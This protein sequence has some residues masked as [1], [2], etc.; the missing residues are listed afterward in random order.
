MAA[1]LTE[2]KR[3]RTSKKKC[4]NK[5]LI[6]TFFFLGGE[7]FIQGRPEKVVSRTTPLFAVYPL[8]VAIIVDLVMCHMGKNER[9]QTSSI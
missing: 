6:L 5:E 1:E 8:I 3:K 9:K 2:L 4:Y 7:A